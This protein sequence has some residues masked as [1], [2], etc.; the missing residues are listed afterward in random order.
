MHRPEETPQQRILK[1]MT[2]GKKISLFHQLRRDAW[3]LK[4]AALR[5]Q[6]PDWSAAQVEDEV[7]MRF[8]YA[9]S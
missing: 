3:Q 6:H 9:R 5:Q 1:K 4:A 2:P 8:L 7:R